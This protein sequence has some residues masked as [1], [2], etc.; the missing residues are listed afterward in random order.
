MSF[1]ISWLTYFAWFHG[2]NKKMLRMRWGPQWQIGTSP[3]SDSRYM[4]KWFPWSCQFPPQDEKIGSQQENN[5]LPKIQGV[6][7]LPRL[8]SGVEQLETRV[9]APIDTCRKMCISVYSIIGLY[10]Y[11]YYIYSQLL[12]TCLIC[13][14]THVHIYL[15][16]C[17]YTCYFVKGHVCFTS[18]A[19]SFHPFIHPFIHVQ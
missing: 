5:I 10:I 16:L 12:C 2:T 15:F 3:L 7:H 8:E 18:I 1:M 6:L 9:V 4:F 17:I 14:Y 13:V 11:T 19:V